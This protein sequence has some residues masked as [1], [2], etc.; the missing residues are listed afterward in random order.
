M[1][2]YAAG[3]LDVGAAVSFVGRELSARADPIAA[4]DMARYLK[5]EMPFYGVKTPDRAPI[6]AE[7]ARRWVPETPRDYERLI[8]ALWR[9]PHRE[10]KY[11]ALGVAERHKRFVTLDSIPLYRRLIVEGAW[12]DLVDGVAANLVGGVL[13][14]SRAEM[15]PVIR[16][17][18]EDK[19]M[20]LRRTAI[21][22]QLNHKAATDATLL[23]E[24]CARRA[25]EKEFFIRKAIG[26]AL[27]QY[28]RTDPEAVRRFV[29]Q[30]E[31]ELSGLSKRE[32]LKHL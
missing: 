14:R 25:H 13:L 18:L 4:V 5:T 28:A 10:E 22:S 32:A 17:W 26:W 3:V 21:I 2:S 20:W 6:A 9:Q 15:T 31:H 12:W 16:D 27:R 30:H 19:D 11:L 23:F 7:M 29:N 8:L 24:C 1:R